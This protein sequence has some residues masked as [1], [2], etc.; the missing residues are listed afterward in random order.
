MKKIDF[1]FSEN[2]MRLFDGFVGKEMNCFVY[3]RLPNI[4][5]TIYGAVVIS[6][7]NEFYAITNFHETVDYINRRDDVGIFKIS[8]INQ[9]RY[10]EIFAETTPVKTPIKQKITNIKIVNEVQELI[11]DNTVEF[12]VQTVRGIVF[13]LEDGR[14]ISFEK[15]IWF[16]E[17][18]EV[19]TGYDLIDSFASTD[20]FIEEWE[21]SI[22]TPSIT[23]SIH[24]IQ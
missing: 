1:R 23:R 9:E 10:N 22:Y 15:D 13:I 14:E 8:L 20:S 2:S 11:Q 21:D 3:E 5:S 24:T 4:S 19:K 18:I 6:I 7:D 12:E 16:S 17:F